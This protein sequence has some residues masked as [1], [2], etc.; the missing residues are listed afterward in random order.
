LVAG[1][2][3]FGALAI[4][5]PLFAEDAARPLAVFALPSL[6]SAVLGG[7]R[8]T[9]VVGIASLLAAVVY[10]LAGPLGTEPLIARWIVVAGAAV[11]GAVGASVRQRQSA[12]LA[13]LDEAMA[14]RQAFER[15][16]APAPVV[17]DGFVAVS[18]YQPAESRM[19][20]GG[21]FL[22][23]V[24]LADGRLAVLVGDVCG[25][26]PREAAF[27]AA[28]RAGWKSIALGGQRDP[29]EWVEALD[30]AFFRDGRIDTYATLCTGYLDLQARISRLVNLGHPPPLWLGPPVRP[31][32]LPPEPPLGLGLVER[33]T[34]TDV[35]WRGEPVL[36]Y[37]DGLIENPKAHGAAHRWGVDGLVAWLSIQP[38]EVTAPALDALI[39]AA[40]AGREVRDD[41]AV[42]VVAAS[43]AAATADP[44]PDPAPAA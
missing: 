7:W 42:L 39:D 5:Y 6:I 25:H 34:A 30:V 13:D 11:M 14:L 10:G 1:L 27:G 26:G 37:T 43:D 32:D 24:A 40:T 8:P 2:V 31:I 19:Q 20:I 4:S 12:R 22:E 38:P 41:I 28:L 15:A 23:A 35:P 3:L 36:F 18:R 21:D 17:P 44:A 29:A 9:V 16:L 33:W